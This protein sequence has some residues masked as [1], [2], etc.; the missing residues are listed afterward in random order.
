MLPFYHCPLNY[1]KLQPIYTQDI[2]NF[3]PQY[4]CTA[5]VI[6]LRLM[7]SVLRKNIWH[8]LMRASS[9]TKLYE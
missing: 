3:P 5:V 4:F 6:I 1:F 2:S 8:T 9:T 7:L